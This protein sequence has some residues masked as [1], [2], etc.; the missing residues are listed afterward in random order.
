MGHW[1]FIIAYTTESNSTM[2]INKK[3]NTEP[4]SGWGKLEFLAIL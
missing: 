2:Y 3:I 1:E 4:W